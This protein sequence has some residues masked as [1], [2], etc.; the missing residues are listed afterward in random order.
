MFRL[1]KLGVSMMA[2]AAIAWFG[3]T[4][5]LGSRTLFQHLRAIGQITESQELVD[6]TKQA[7]GP[8]VDD[9]RR[10]ISGKSESEVSAASAERGK[11]RP[12]ASGATPESGKR[13]PSGASVVVGA[14]PASRVAPQGRPLVIYLGTLGRVPN[15]PRC[16]RLGEAQAPS[17]RIYLGNPRTGSEP[18]AMCS[19]G[20]SPSSSTR[21]YLGTLGRVPNLPRCARFGDTRAITGPSTRPTPGCSWAPSPH[22]S[23][24]LERCVSSLGSPSAP[25]G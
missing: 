10:R 18:P 1:L 16:A 2:L 23:R 15:L 20:R 17:T 4:V 6:G 25:P 7:A 11:T 12:G 13:R 5:K 22:V 19:L 9:V 3:I 21:I 14:T 24:K 8:L